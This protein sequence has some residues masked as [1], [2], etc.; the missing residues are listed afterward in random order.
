MEPD[1]HNGATILEDK[2]GSP[3]SP[4]WTSTKGPFDP[5]LNA[6]PWQSCAPVL[7]ETG[8]HVT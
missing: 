4:S 5:I 3:S 1:L 8:W 6:Q 7:G 2:M